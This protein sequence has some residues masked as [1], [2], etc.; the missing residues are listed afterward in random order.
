M[1]DLSRRQIQLVIN[2]LGY[3]ISDYEKM[4][5]DNNS[6]SDDYPLITKYYIE[7]KAELNEVKIYFEELR[8]RKQC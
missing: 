6:N 4:I 2:A 1:K 8:E 7:S 3:N 5:E